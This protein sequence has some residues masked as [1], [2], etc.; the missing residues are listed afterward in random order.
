MVVD[1][2][3]KSVVCDCYEWLPGTKKGRCFIY[4]HKV[5]V[6]CE[7]AKRMVFV[8]IQF[9]Q[10]LMLHFTKENNTRV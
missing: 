2:A 9:D 4:C 6:S 1:S 10:L 3:L 5:W 7:E 8:S